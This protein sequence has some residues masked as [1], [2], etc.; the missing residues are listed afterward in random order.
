VYISYNM[1]NQCISAAININPTLPIVGIYYIGQY[2]TS[3][4]AACSKSYLFHFFSLGIPI[5]WEPLY[6][7]DSKMEDNDIY[8]IVIK[9]LINKYISHYDMVI[10]CSTPDLWPTFRKEKSHIINGKIVIG[11]C[12]WETN[13]LPADWVKCINESVNELWVPSTYNEKYFKESGVTC[14][15]RVVPYVFL[16]K[17]L[18]PKSQIRIFNSHNSD[19]LK[20]N[21]KYTFY[22]IGEWNGR[23][24]IDDTI[25]AFCESF[26]DK[27]AVRL[28]VKVHYNNYTPTN[29]Q[30]CQKFVSEIINSYSN[31]PEILCITENLTNDEIL[32]LHSLG[33]CYIS[34]TKSEGFGLTIFDA[35]NYNKQIITTGYGGHID[36]LGETYPGLV[37]YTVGPVKGMASEY[38]KHDHEWAY[39]DIEHAKHLMKL[40]YSSFRK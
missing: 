39:P 23:K 9:S 13:R 20:D 37:K 32:A 28:I 29:K 36:F 34:L 40:A 22:S 10:M 38:Y 12:T 8:N 18:I 11:C 25:K 35:F 2:G 30:K 16:P 15:I 3:G 7:D 24:G 33:D 19:I 6:F 5:T 4:Y 1:S 27:D 26:T 17:T 21:S 14:I 31:P